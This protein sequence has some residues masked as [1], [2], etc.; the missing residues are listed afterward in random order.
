M[1]DTSFRVVASSLRPSSSCNDENVEKNRSD[2]S[3]D[4]CFTIDEISDQTGL[5]LV[6]VDFD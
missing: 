3:E 4:H 5:E 6:P 2:F 1:L